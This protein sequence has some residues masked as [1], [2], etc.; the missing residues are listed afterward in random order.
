MHK[1]VIIVLGLASFGACAQS[2]MAR[3]L[4]EDQ[5][6]ACYAALGRTVQKHGANKCEAEY[7][8]C[9]RAH[10]STQ[11]NSYMPVQTV[12]GLGTP[13]I[14]PY[15]TGAVPV[16]PGDVASGGGTQTVAAR[17]AHNRRRLPPT[18]TD[19]GTP[20]QGNTSVLNGTSFS[21][22]S[23]SGV[24]S[25]SGSAVSTT[26]TAPVSSAAGGGGAP[27]SSSSASTSIKQK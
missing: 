15:P 1:A 24:S 26:S 5:R 8:R 7:A 4:C 2:A 14:K 12:P 6:D 3:S 11:A 20:S 25:A 9:L 21:G 17:T 16:T 13:M 18:S 23:F 19:G 10:A 22:G 27:I